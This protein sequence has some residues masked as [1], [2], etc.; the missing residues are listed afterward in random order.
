MHDANENKGTTPSTTP[1]I[2][3][4]TTIFS[5]DSSENFHES[6]FPYSSV[7]QSREELID[8]LWDLWDVPL[9]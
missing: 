9:L 7:F 2:V 5:H 1:S 3:N 4:E 6:E 8:K